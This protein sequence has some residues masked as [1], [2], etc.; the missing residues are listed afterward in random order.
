M[1]T[2]CPWEELLGS[3]CSAT[4]VL[5]SK[6]EDSSRGN[7]FFCVLSCFFFPT[8]NESDEDLGDNSRNNQVVIMVEKVKG[9]LLRNY[10]WMIQKMI[11]SNLRDMWDDLEDGLRDV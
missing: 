10:C 6:D 11:K 3:D 9:Q 2:Y 1:M 4:I 5:F 7:Y 8:I